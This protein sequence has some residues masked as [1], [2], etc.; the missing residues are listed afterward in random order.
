MNVRS[1]DGDVVGPTDGVID[2]IFVGCSVGVLV[3]LVGEILEFTDGNIV[4]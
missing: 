3:K 1:A 4:E 2:G